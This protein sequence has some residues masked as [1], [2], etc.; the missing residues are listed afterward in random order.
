MRLNGTST[1]LPMPNNSLFI[2]SLYTSLPIFHMLHNDFGGPLCAM[3][4]TY[5]FNEIAFGVCSIISGVTMILQE[6]HLT[7]QIEVYTMIH[8]IIHPRLHT[9]RRTEIHPVYLTHILD[10][11]PCPRQAYKTRMELRQIMLQNSRRVSG[12]VTSDKDW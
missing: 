6:S 9:L 3:L 4:S 12:R 10:L 7:H 5:G 8:Q 2:L 11:L 1:T